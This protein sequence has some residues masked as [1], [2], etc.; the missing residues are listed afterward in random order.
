MIENDPNSEHLVYELAH[1]AYLQGAYEQATA[2]FRFILLFNPESFIGWFGLGSSLLVRSQELRNHEEEA[3]E[4]VQHECL[5]HDFLQR[6]LL[7]EALQAAKI[8]EKLCP[9]DAKCI[10]LQLEIHLLQHE[11]AEQEINQAE[12]NSLIAKAEALVSQNSLL[13]KELELIKIKAKR[14]TVSV[15]DLHKRKI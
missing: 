2:Y 5:Q 3:K 7:E 15:F 6:E 8:A 9:T 10:L 1:A 11:W 14:K 12:Q 13:Q 4:G